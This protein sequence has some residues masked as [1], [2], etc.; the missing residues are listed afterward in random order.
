MVQGF[1]MIFFFFMSI[2]ETKFGIFLTLII[3]PEGLH[4]CEICPSMACSNAHFELHLSFVSPL[5]IFS[6]YFI[7]LTHLFLLVAVAC[8]NEL[9]QFRIIMMLLWKM[10]SSMK[11]I[12]YHF[13]WS[14]MPLIITVY[15]CFFP[16]AWPVLIDDFVEHMYRFV[17]SSPISITFFGEAWIVQVFQ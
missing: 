3:F 15:C 10:T 2:L 13:S 9:L 12:L 5:F 17:K 1:C 8:M 16:G 4:L 14:F 6:A 7:W 11:Y